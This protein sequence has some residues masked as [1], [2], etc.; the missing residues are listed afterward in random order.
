M[1]NTATEL[2][3]GDLAHLIFTF[4]SGIR[5]IGKIHNNQEDLISSVDTALEIL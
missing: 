3:S 1:V 4:Y 5:V 2:A